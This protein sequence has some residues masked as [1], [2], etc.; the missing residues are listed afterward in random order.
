MRPVLSALLLA[1]LILLGKVSAAQQYPLYRYSVEDGLAH[2]NVFRIMQ[3]ARGFLWFSTN[4]GLSR[5]DGRRFV[6][7]LSAD[8][9][10]DNMVMSVSEDHLGQ[11]WICTF[12]NGLCYLSTDGII[13]P[14]ALS[15]YLPKKTIFCE[16]LADVKWLIG[17]DSLR[18]LYS[19]RNAQVSRLQ[20]AGRSAK[21][22][23]FYKIIKQQS[24]LYVLSDNGIYQIG[25]DQVLRPFLPAFIS[26]KVTDM[27]QGFGTDEYWVGMQGAILHL[28]GG[29]LLERY[30]L[31]SDE[32]T[33]MQVDHGGRLWVSA[34]DEGILVIEDHK[35]RNLSANV[36]IGNIL[37]NDVFADAEGNIW[38]ATHG[39]GVCR[40]NSLDFV[41]YPIEKEVMNAYC[42]A[43]V[44]H[45]PEVYTGSF[46]TISA[47]KE[48]KLVPVPI[49]SIKHRYF[50]YFIQIINNVLYIGTPYGL[51]VKAIGA[52]PGRMISPEPEPVGV[53]SMC[54]DRSGNIW[55][56]SYSRLYRMD[57]K[58][59]TIAVEP[60]APFGK[61][62]NALCSDRQDRLWLGTGSGIMMRK[63][64]AFEPLTSESLGS[65]NAIYEDSSSGDIW[66][67]ADKGLA[68]Y[69]GKRLN[70]LSHAGTATTGHFNTIG[71][72]SSGNIWAGSTGGLLSVD[73]RSLKV[74]DYKTDIGEVLSILCRGQQMF[75]GTVNGLSIIRPSGVD[76]PKAPVVYITTVVTDTSQLSF[77][78]ELRLPYRH[79]KLRIEFAGLHF[80]FPRSVEY[81]YRIEGLDTTWHQTTSN[82]LEIPSLPS[83]AYRFLVSVRRNGGAW[84][85]AAVLP[86]N[87][88]TPLWRNG[89]FILV[90]I[91]L[92][93]LLLYIIIRAIVKRVEE[94]KRGQLLL[95]NKMLYLKQ[96]ALGA[97]INPHFIFNAMNSIQHY[98]NRSDSAK[99]NMY[100]ADFAGLIRL[101]LQHGQD[102]FIELNTEV[103]R[104]RL[105][106][107]LEQLRTGPD[108]QFDITVD[109]Q[110]QGKSLYI[111]NMVLQPYVE[112]AI[113]HGIIPKDSPGKLL[114]SFSRLPHG[115]IEVKVQD[116]GLGYDPAALHDTIAARHKGLGMSLTEERLA[117]FQSLMDKDFSV[118]VQAVNGINGEPT[119][120]IVRI[121]LPWIASMDEWQALEQRYA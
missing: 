67:A 86:I 45:G 44:H 25:V 70:I 48:G 15:G 50:V 52:D 102:A 107:S 51:V 95:F 38:F 78:S 63:N 26:G 104:L 98:L 100:L 11:K 31:N 72:D 76:D 112:N 87:V 53:I 93:T 3:D 60:S 55:L 21:P 58:T 40:L 57:P 80:R 19:I 7:F 13:K 37:I 92:F 116:D 118:K 6:N 18:D 121:T 22:V 73:P 4:F 109:A 2:A 101:T 111:P 30:A 62:I 88:A 65:I 32:V 74:R 47:W 71:G 110:L 20:V 46:G 115:L 56:G 42:K 120:T 85:Q 59:R 23:Q 49:P 16:E 24:V 1:L 41:R 82:T 12:G 36:T 105:Y 84:S 5:F 69:R 8:G 35:L 91:L 27:Q 89:W 66:F 14:A 108:L 99:A 10:G 113:W 119:G 75:L 114:V 61:R 9:T 29:K 64:G 81:R 68:V 79:N 17:I 90:A 34:A 28:Q 33:D 97:L 77:P 106:L 94:R 83:G 117:L 43:L 54:N 96:Q 103:A 39:E